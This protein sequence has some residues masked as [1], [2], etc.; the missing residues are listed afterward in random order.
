MTA[1]FAYAQA[2]GVDAV[3]DRL[4][5]EDQWGAGATGIVTPDSFRTTT[6][7]GATPMSVTIGPGR[8]VIYSDVSFNGSYHCTQDEDTVLNLGTA[9]STQYRRDAIIARVRDASLVSGDGDN[10]FN[11]EVVPGA[12]SA[13][14][15]PPLP[16][17]PD[18]SML[19]SD[20]VI[21]PNASSPSKITDRREMVKPREYVNQIT[22]VQNTTVVVNQNT[23]INI[24]GFFL[25]NWPFWARHGGHRCHHKISS[26]A[27][28]L[29]AGEALMR[30][31]L[32]NSSGDDQCKT[33]P[34]PQKLYSAGMFN[35]LVSGEYV[36]PALTTPF[37]QLQVQ[38]VGS[39]TTAMTF[40]TQQSVVTHEI[41]VYEQPT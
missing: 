16:A 37:S 27:R 23:Y 30:A 5:I 36:L 22:I 41:R 2:V 6:G 11:I 9:S 17:L 35:Y 12:N 3:T 10:S 39:Q 15:N 24:N 4:Q 28:I 40:E 25:P 31:I 19:L 38:R 33:V 18:R 14:N 32:G 21:N 29:A 1:R 8:G 13:S 34:F 7:G 26:T 20:I